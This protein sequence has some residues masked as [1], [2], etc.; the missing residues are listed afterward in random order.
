VTDLFG[1]TSMALPLDQGKTMVPST[2]T[3]RTVLKQSGKALLL[4]PWLLA[5][6]SPPKGTSV[7]SVRV[8]ILHSQTGTMALSG[9]AVRNGEI[10][11][12]EEINETGGIL[13]RPIEII[14]EDPRSR[15]DLFANYA[16][17]LLTKD[18]VAAV[19]GCWTSASRKNVLPIFE[20]YN[21]LLF[22]PLQYE[23][24]ESSPNII[25]SGAVPNQQVLPALDWLLSAAG[26]L[27]KRIYLIGSNYI[28]PQTIHFLVKKYLATKSITVVGEELVP[29]DE[30]DYVDRV[31]AIRA[32]EPDIILSNV[33]GMGSLAF[34]KEWAA[35]K[36][37]P[38][39]VTMVSGSVNET[40]LQQLP[41]ANLKGHLAL[42]SYFQSQNQPTNLAFVKR[43]KAE[44]GS[45]CAVSDPIATAYSQVMLWKQAVEKAQSVDPMK[46][47]EAIRT[48]VTFENAPGYPLRIDPRTQHAY[49]HCMIGR[50]RKDRQFDIV[51][52]SPQA[53]AP[54]PYPSFA[55]PGWNCDW[56]KN[57]LTRGAEVKISQ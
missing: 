42:W 26:G 27:R 39:R 4:S 34:I 48:G 41:Q 43:Y 35:T 20:K 40:E 32:A 45:S 16:E 9:M 28:Y 22:Y 33:V 15:T 47:R 17:K 56:T 38:D 10:L 18:K 7:E 6:C 46:V 19:F 3:R 29:L 14:E 55:F 31:K 5:G 36:I 13:G 30:L 23:G 51:Y 25:Y 53:I 12:I 1:A 52:E 54:E 11:A 44:F 50:I 49:R 37:S 21:G 2:P 57:G 8:G 24:N